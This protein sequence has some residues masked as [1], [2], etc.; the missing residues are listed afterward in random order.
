M[1]DVLSKI[2]LVGWGPI[3][4]I[5]A[6][7]VQLPHHRAPAVAQPQG[8]AL[9]VRLSVPGVRRRHRR[10]LPEH[11]VSPTTTTWRSS[12][13]SRRIRPSTATP[14][15]PVQQQPDGAVTHDHRARHNS[16]FGSFDANVWLPP[17][18]FSDPR[19]TSRFFC[20]MGT[21]PTRLAE[22]QPA[23]EPGSAAAQADHPVI[24]VF[25]AVL[26][27]G[28]TGDTLCVDTE[29]QG[30]AETYLLKDV[31]PTIDNHSGPVS[32]SSSGPSVVCRWA[33]TAP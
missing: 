27:D 31:I 25:P 20:C 18:Y 32:T 21:R 3:L 30:N 22:R 4:T 17:Q 26:Q 24:L 2:P 6:I 11:P 15:V 13:D 9:G 16:N 14:A 19:H 8:L 7:A 1:T 33:A 12:P 29:S 5:A 28:F 23:A 10:G